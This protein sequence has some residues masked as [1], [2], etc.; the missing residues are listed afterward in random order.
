MCRYWKVFFEIDSCT[1]LQMNGAYPG[2]YDLYAGPFDYYG[3][4]PFFSSYP[5]NRNSKKS[6]YEKER[7]NSKEGKDKDNNEKPK[8]KEDE[9]DE[10]PNLQEDF[11]SISA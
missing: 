7:S 2:Y 8:T 6:H 3:D 10:K 1:L 9:E 11:V 4:Q 5:S